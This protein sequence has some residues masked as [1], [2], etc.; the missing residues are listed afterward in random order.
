MSQTKVRLIGVENGE[1]ISDKLIDFLQNCR[2][3]VL[4]K[5][6]RTMFS[7]ILGQ[8]AAKR[9]IPI[10]P[11]QE[12]L[13]Q[14]ALELAHDD[15]AIFASGDP[16]FFGIG[17]TLLQVFGP[18]RIMVYPARSSMQ[19]A[20][21]RFK[22]PWDD[23]RFLSLH[24]R[25]TDNLAASI[26]IHDKVFLFTDHSF[27]PDMI[28]RSLLIECGKGI[29]SDYMVHVAE[30]L[31]MDNERLHTGTLSEIAVRSFDPLNVM[32]LLKIVPPSTAPSFGLSE[33]EIAH[34]RGLITKNEV[35][36]ASLHA[37]RLPRQGVFWDVGAGSG[38]VGLE[39]ARL[40]PELQVFAVEREDE[41]IGN[42]QRNREQF[43][44]WNLQVFHGSAPDTLASLPSPDRVFIGGSGGH[45]RAIIEHAAGRLN[46]GG[47]IV[48]NAVLE[49][50]AQNAPAFLHEQGLTTSLSEIRVTRSSYPQAM[51]NPTSLAPVTNAPNEVPLGR[52]DRPDQGTQTMHPITIIVGQKKSGPGENR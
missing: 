18:E 31:E 2:V 6:H 51:E 5:R 15:V 25:E 33:D 1:Q 34:S 20:F 35:R 47:R 17:R 28:A 50:T 49:K 4:S 12:A 14:V 46:P 9:L 23:A 30:N 40:F 39:A 11:V 48:V 26:L 24:G 29:N 3:L 19:I 52:E 21:S 36:A 16:L 8:Q 32:I 7:S 41:Q 45:L 42:I 38:A 37:L 44:T 43:Q 13:T 27:S 10:A 22:I